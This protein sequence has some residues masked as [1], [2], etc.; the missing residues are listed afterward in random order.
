MHTHTHY[1]ILYY[2]MYSTYYSKVHTIYTHTHN[3]Y[4]YIHIYV[5]IVSIYS[6]CSKLICENMEMGFYSF[7]IIDFS[8]RT[9]TDLG[10]GESLYYILF[11]HTLSFE[12]IALI[13]DLRSRL[14]SGDS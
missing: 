12:S 2:S 9:R 7:S 1:T 13:N 3:I 11:V 5:Y 4:I 14:F 10:R 6:N 8:R